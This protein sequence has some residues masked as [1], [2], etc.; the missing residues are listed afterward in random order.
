MQ[1][2]DNFFA[3]LSFIPQQRPFFL[4]YLFLSSM[5]PSVTLSPYPFMWAAWGKKAK[6]KVCHFSSVANPSA[7]I[8]SWNIM[9]LSWGN[10]G[11]PHIE[12]V[13]INS[14][15]IL[16]PLLLCHTTSV[17]CEIPQGCSNS[18]TDGVGQ[19]EQAAAPF[20]WA[21]TQHK[22]RFNWSTRCNTFSFLGNI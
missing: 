15:M 8:A 4:Q 16:S 19:T 3:L 9:V 2:D 1:M 22:R 14:L 12:M 6:A 7:S 20:W 17:L 18:L 13:I 21:V 5:S 10:S 11:F